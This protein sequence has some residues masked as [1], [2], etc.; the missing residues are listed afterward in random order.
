MQVLANQLLIKSIKFC[1]TSWFVS[2]NIIDGDSIDGIIKPC[3][4]I[5]VKAL[6]HLNDITILLLHH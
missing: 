2:L 6:I 3:R 4:M 5:C 1:G